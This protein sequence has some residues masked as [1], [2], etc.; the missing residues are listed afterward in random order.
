MGSCG[1]FIVAGDSFFRVLV[2]LVLL[3]D[4]FVEVFF[5]GCFSLL[6]F[7][8]CHFG[9]GK[10]REFPED[11]RGGFQEVFSV[12]YALF[13]ESCVFPDEGDFVRVVAGFGVTDVGYGGA[14]GA[15]HG[16]EGVEVACEVLV[17]PGV[18]VSV[19]CDADAVEVAG[20]EGGVD[21]P[22]GVFAVRGG[23]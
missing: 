2:C 22:V 17:R 13:D 18:G 10:F 12:V 1:E 21:Y 9:V 7:F 23:V 8:F 14:E 3:A 11:T 4:A 6:Q 20:L 16:I 15:G 19:A 5:Q